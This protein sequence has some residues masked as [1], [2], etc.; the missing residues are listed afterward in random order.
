MRNCQFMQTNMSMK[1]KMKCFLGD[2]KTTKVQTE[3]K[4]N[5]KAKMKA[6][7]TAKIKKL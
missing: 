7:S 3:I 6:E 5:K 2:N 1:L 4:A